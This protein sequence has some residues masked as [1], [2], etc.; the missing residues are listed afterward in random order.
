MYDEEVEKT[1]LYYLIFEEEE[2]KLK[3][4]DFYI[5]KNRQIYNAIEELRK[6]REE[7][8]I[9][10]IK[11]AIKGKDT[12]ILKY[13]SEIA[14]SRYESSFEYAYKKIKELSKKRQLEEFNTNLKVE[15]NEGIE[16]VEIYIEK[17]IK[18]LIEIND[19]EKKEETFQEA[20]VET[21]EIIEQKY[22]QKEKYDNKYT[23]G[24]FDLDEVTNG[25][26]KGE[27]T[28]IGAR[29]GVGKT[30]FALKIAQNIASK[31]LKVAIVSLEMSKVQLI[32]RLIAKEARIDSAK[33]KT[34]ILTEKE[35]EKIAEAEISVFNLPIFI[36][37][38]T[39]NIQ[40]V[41]IYARKLK[42]K[43]DI[44]LLIIDYLQLMKSKNK[45]YS[46]EQEVSEITRTLKLLS[47]ELNI[48]IIA[49][50]QLN[51]N[52]AKNEPTLSDLRES[53]AIEQDADN[54]IF[55]YSKSSN[56]E[57]PKSVE[58]IVIDLQKQRTGALT[59]VT[60]RFDKTCN[61]FIN[62]IRRN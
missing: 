40:D 18:K 23:T 34:G 38:R 36:S 11:N 5:T 48:P 13:I 19:E 29:P 39:R 37:T 30:A 50:C 26:Q 52:A 43:E 2:T 62:L 35:I 41:E 10:S 56:D 51:R 60:V 27:L 8:N 58:D 33:L 57:K 21:S 24:I 45:L 3:P 1:I 31:G 53:G 42:N 28:I 9:L 44:G 47:L 7:V 32:Q 54:V 46:R 15:L 25:L 14:E 59:T 49:L 61:E 17:Q 6:K 55:L 20:V 22:L 4:E 12:D 16:D